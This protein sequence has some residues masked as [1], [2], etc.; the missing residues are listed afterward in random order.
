MDSPFSAS[1]K[2]Q[3]HFV[4]SLAVPDVTLGY[5]QYDAFINLIGISAGLPRGKILLAN[6]IVENVTL[7]S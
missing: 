7:L 6:V 1:A 3:S 2:V 5:R 4:F